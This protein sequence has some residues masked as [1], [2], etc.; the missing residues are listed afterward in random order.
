MSSVVNRPRLRSNVFFVPIDDGVVFFGNEERTILKGK[1]IYQWVRSLLPLLDGRSAIKEL[2]SGL[3]EAQRAVVVR[4]VE[5][6]AKAGFIA[7]ADQTAPH[8]L[9]DRTLSR[10]ASEI[11]FL[12]YFTPSPELAFQHYREA[13]PLLVGSGP[14]LIQLATAML[15][16]GT[17][18]VRV[19]LVNNHATSRADR[20]QLLHHY[21][22]AR[23][24]DPEQTLTVL[25]V[26]DDAELDDLIRSA[27]VVL[28]LADRPMFGRA[29]RIARLTAE[30][31]AVA[32]QGLVFDE[33][34]WIG[35]ADGAGA[36]ESRAVSAWQRLL[37]WSLPGPV[38]LIDEPDAAPS[39][40]LTGP[41]PAIVAQHLCLAAFRLLAGV[42]T[43]DT[44]AGVVQI[45][46]ETLRTTTRSLLPH[47]AAS[48]AEPATAEQ[49]AARIRALMEG[50]AV[51]DDELSRR[52]IRCVD[53]RL[54][55]LGE[56]SEHDYAQIP[57]YVSE[58]TVADPF[59]LLGHE[60][61]ELVDHGYGDNFGEA[62]RE[63]ARN[64]LRRYA[65]LAAD[66]R[67]IGQDT[68]WG[69]DL[70]KDE[71]VSVPCASAFPVLGAGTGAHGVP[72]GVALGEDWHDAVER[73]LRGVWAQRAA[74]LA[75][76]TTSPVPTVDLAAVPLSERDARYREQLH[77]LGVQVEVVDLG[78]IVGVQ[79]YAFLRE[80][81]TVAYTADSTTAGAIGRGLALLLLDWQ[82]T[83]HGQPGYGPAHVPQLALTRL[84]ATL[85]KGGDSGTA[86]L[87]AALAERG[88]R[89]VAVPLDHDHALKQLMPYLIHVVVLDD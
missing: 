65:V 2:T 30:Q 45:D 10:Y 34:A 62:R 52:V 12:D 47:P 21:E 44:P 54:G 73:G 41:T 13:A 53:E 1:N 42:E 57:L 48:P 61:P 23:A 63:A 80:G 76:E 88:Q 71:P 70:A 75:A 8:S 78:S 3:S 15:R 58:V 81:R 17:Q 84:D 16:T 37:G 9:N 19:A 5:A 64:G 14:L 82:A 89:V 66:R 6:L 29:A 77:T 72:E 68:V 18:D 43:D 22:A 38:R 31:G 83:H 49:F 4:L 35:P 50:P 55:I 11:A 67:Q 25:D 60:R 32:V 79:A 27:R 40:Y 7:D 33:S 87:L 39:T 74:A 51:T 69:W 26:T 28:H 46:L 86:D 56:V 20:D 85:G 36:G 59:G 24:D